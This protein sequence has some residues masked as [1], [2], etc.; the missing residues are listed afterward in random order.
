MEGS[1]SEDEDMDGE[2]ALEINGDPLTSKSAFKAVVIN[3]LVE[4]QLDSKRASKME[5]LDFLTLLNAM[6]AANIHFR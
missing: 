1:D 5:I 3:V 6:N 4:N 2:G